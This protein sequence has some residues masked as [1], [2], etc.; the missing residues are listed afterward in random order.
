MSCTWPVL[1]LQDLSFLKEGILD[2]KDTENEGHHETK[3]LYTVIML[4]MLNS[5]I[6]P[7]LYGLASP[8]YRRGFLKAFDLTSKVE[9]TE[10]VELNG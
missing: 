3:F 5:A 7:I 10:V 9:P 2:H 4:K 6:N 8:S 1:N